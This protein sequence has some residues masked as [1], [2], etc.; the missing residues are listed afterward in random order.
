MRQKDKNR[1]EDR[2]ICYS[3]WVIYNPVTRTP[4]A[5]RQNSARRENT[6]NNI[7]FIEQLPEQVKNLI[8]SLAEL[9]IHEA[10]PE[11]DSEE[12]SETL[13]DLM[14]EKIKDIV[15]LLQEYVNDLYERS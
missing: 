2:T 11:L 3:S 10:N 5:E 1:L 14:N 6:M 9:E 12:I 7:M 8:Y 13:A 15:P 4:K